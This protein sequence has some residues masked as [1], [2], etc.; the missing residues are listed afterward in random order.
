[1]NVS[2][3]SAAA[4]VLSI[5]AFAVDRYNMTPV[6]QFQFEE[7]VATTESAFERGAIATDALRYELRIERL[8]SK[9]DRDGSL[10]ERDQ[11]QLDRAYERLENIEE[12]MARPWHG[13]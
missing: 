12:E 13:E 6:V 10:S 8:E 2:I 7:H 9:K 4:I 11:N 3:V 1:M 5:L